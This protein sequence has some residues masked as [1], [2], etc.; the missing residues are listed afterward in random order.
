MSLTKTISKLSFF[1]SLIFVCKLTAGQQVETIYL[2][3]GDSSSNL[4]IVVKPSQPLK[5]FAMFIPG[6]FQKAKDVLVQTDLP[7]YAA[8]QGIL[9]I[10]PTFKTGIA[11][12]GVDSATQS[13]LLE[14]L[15][16]ITDKYKLRGLRFYLG[17]FS[18]G[19]SCVLRYSELAL[20]N[21]YAIKPTAIFAID[22][23]LDF[24]R[25]YNTFIR[26][27]RL[28]TDGKAPQEE[29]E[30]LIKRFNKEFGG[31]PAE[32]LVNYRKL[33]PYSFSDTTQA[34]IKPL[35]NLPIRLYTEPDIQWWLNDGADYTGMNAL[36]FS[37]MTNEL[38]R[39][40]N[41]RITMITTVNK[42]YRKPGNIRHPHSWSIVDS[43]DLVKW[44]LMQN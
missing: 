30:Y 29:G 7:V 21:N 26:E 35:K 31:T 3:P 34:A 1:L 42:G 13:S 9:T 15:N 24:E 18:I 4:Y 43:K 27:K 37:A 41:N 20:S 36:D 22:S 25:M 40:G 23:P 5:G 28:I 2:N 12:L 39:L 8:Q 10:I 32:S 6:M 19:G 33:S 17:G 16:H 44:L 38:M 11:S 14:I